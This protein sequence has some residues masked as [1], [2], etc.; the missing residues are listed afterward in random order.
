MKLGVRVGLGPDHI[1]LDGDPAPPPQ[2]AL[3]FN[4]FGLTMPIDAQKDVLG[5]FTPKWGQSHQDLKRDPYTTYKSLRSVHPF[6]HSSPINQ[7][8]RN[9]MLSNGP[10]TPPKLLLPVAASTPM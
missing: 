10:G 9:P 1:V 8:P 4:E 7:I 5:H 2:Q 6:L 3:I